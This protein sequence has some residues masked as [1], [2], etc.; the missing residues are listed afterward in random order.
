MNPTIADKIKGAIVGHAVGDALGLGTEFMHRREA[1]VRY[2]N[3][4]K[5]YSEI[6]RDA[7]RSIWTRGNWTSCTSALFL[8]LESILEKGDI[9]PH[10]I[11]RRTRDWFLMHPAGIDPEIRFIYMQPDY[12]DDP[13]AVAE[14]VWN[15]MDQHRAPNDPIAKA[16]IAG[17][18]DRDGHATS[19]NLCRLTH[20]HPRCVA[21]AAIIDTMTRSLLWNNSPAPYDTLVEIGREYAPDSLPYLETA[22]FGA[23]QDLHLD[24]PDDFWFVR[25]TMAS[26]LWPVWH[27]ETLEEGLDA[28][29]AEAGDAC[30]NASIATSL[31]GLKF[32]FK[33]IPSHLTDTLVRIDDAMDLADRFVKAVGDRFDNA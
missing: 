6:V 22:R 30:V 4:L 24:D 31:L 9:E 33:A 28:V 17:I 29:V 15:C 27:S 23:I 1:A 20:P 5:D 21:S 32:G 3:G 11:A 25:K 13:Y 26:A 16:V 10:D 19:R 8:V 2:P 14:R 18:W 12:L 7:H